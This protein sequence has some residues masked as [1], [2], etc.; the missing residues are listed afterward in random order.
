MVCLELMLHALDIP[1]GQ[2][3]EQAFD[4]SMVKTV[5][6]FRRHLDACNARSKPPLEEIYSQKQGYNK[7]MT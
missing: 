7:W 1:L 6:K 4:S 2:P 3:T 5:E